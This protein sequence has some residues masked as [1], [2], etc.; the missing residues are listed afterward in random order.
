MSSSEVL[1]QNDGVE[2]TGATCYKRVLG[3]LQ[4]LS[5]T[6]S[7]ISFSMNKLSQFMHSPSEVHWKAL[8]QVL[9][10]LQG[11]MQFFLRIQIDNDF[12]LHMYSDADWA[13]DASDRA[14]TT[15]YIPFFGKNLLSWSQ[16]KQRIVARSST[17]AE[18]RAI[19]S[20]LAERNWVTIC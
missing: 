17:E 3:K 6:H 10:Y 5:F 7:D 11:T 12:K 15:G 16:R 14:S 4:Y 18:Y 13:V 20:A 9:R 1:Q 8:K 19:S 2:P